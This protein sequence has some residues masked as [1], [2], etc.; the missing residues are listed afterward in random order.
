LA[1]TPRPDSQVSTERIFS[2]STPILFTAFA[3]DFVDELILLHDRGV[4]TG[5]LIVSPLN[6]ADDAGREVDD[7]FV[8]FVDSNAPQCR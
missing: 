5:S 6:A 2:C 7:F 1:Q 4:V 3:V 8:T